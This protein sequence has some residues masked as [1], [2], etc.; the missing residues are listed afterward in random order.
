MWTVNLNKCLSL[1]KPVNI[2]YANIA[3][4]TQCI[5]LLIHNYTCSMHAM[6]RPMQGPACRS[7]QT[8][9]P[10]QRHNTH[11]EYTILLLGLDIIVSVLL[12]EPI[13]IGINCLQN[14]TYWPTNWWHSKALITFTSAYFL[15]ICNTAYTARIL[16]NLLKHRI[17]RQFC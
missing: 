4:N 15:P 14:F 11:S 16:F 10:P 7:S 1:T 5:Y 2:K 13:T 12:S 3:L 8:P 9:I 6:H 17:E